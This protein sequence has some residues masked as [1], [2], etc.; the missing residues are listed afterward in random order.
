MAD[1]R[2]VVI[3]GG[4]G[5]ATV[6]VDALRG[7]RGAII[8]GYVALRE[9]LLSSLDIPWLGN[10][11]VIASLASR[12]MRYVALGVAG[13]A[14]N[15]RRRQLFEHWTAAG[16][17]FVDVVHP[18]A[19]VAR[20]VVHGPGLQALAGAVINPGAH[21]GANVIVNSNATVEHHC[22]IGDHAHIAPGAT[23]CGNVVVGTGCLVGAGAVTA[24]GVRLGHRVVVGAGSAVI[25]D[26][27]DGL[28]VGGAPAR[29]L[30]IK[31]GIQS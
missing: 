21:L 13:A 17:S 10:D 11:D 16:F 8:V 3:I 29:P 5:H 12:G 6:V 20:D 31:Q 4:G 22:E 19:T 23:L 7:A 30:A 15:D 25:R 2:D 14:S 27:A 26:V 24:P 28:T 18:R 9:S 1:S